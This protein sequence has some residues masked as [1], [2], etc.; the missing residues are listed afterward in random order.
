M[1]IF[2]LENC[3][4][5]TL[6]ANS[7]I[8]STATPVYPRDFDSYNTSVEGYR[9]SSRVTF[10]CKAGYALSGPDII[11]CKTNRAWSPGPTCTDIRGNLNISL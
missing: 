10:R 6:P 2:L 9:I 1:F 5:P 7:I 3:F 11:T 4:E 8:S